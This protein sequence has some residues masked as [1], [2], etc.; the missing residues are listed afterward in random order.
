M[1]QAKMREIDGAIG[2]G[3]V[4]RIGIG[5]AAAQGES[6]RIYNIRKSRPKPGLK[7]QHLAGLQ[8]IAELSQAQVEGAKLGSQ[9]VLFMPGRISQQKLSV[10][11]ETAGSVGLALQPLQ[12]ACLAAE[13]PVQVM[14]E[15]GGTFGKWAPPLLYLEL[16]NLAGLKR[17]GYHG[18]VTV[19]RQGFYPKG[20]ARVEALFHHPR[21]TGRL[22]L[23][24]PGRLLRIIGVSLASHHLRRANVAQRQAEAARKLLQ[25]YQ[26]EVSIKTNYADTLSPGSGIVLSA[27]FEHTVLGSDAL[28]ER[29]KPAE[30]VGEEAATSL[31]EDLESG[32]TLDRYMSDQIIPFLGLYGG[33]FRCPQ[34]TAHMETNIELI[35]QLLERKAEL[36]GRWISY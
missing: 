23:S 15:G 34:I 21:I 6:I 4:L 26:V 3:S 20:G 33:R 28:G 31:I 35:E 14:I 11:I 36:A 12:L 17:F 18:E 1:M 30:L 16:V 13:Y 25:R 19:D 22:D 32:A 9:E 7:A 24:E 8:A 2:G 29:G 27:V 10:Q 5:L